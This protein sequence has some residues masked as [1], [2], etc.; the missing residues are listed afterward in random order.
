[1]KQ[2]RVDIPTTTGRNDIGVKVAFSSQYMPSLVGLPNGDVLLA[3]AHCMLRSKDHGRT[4]G[5]IE[6]LPKKLGAITD[7]GDTMFRTAKGRLI[8][9]HFRG[10]KQLEGPMPKVGISES[11]DNGK[12][13]SDTAWSELAGDWAGGPKNLWPYG[14]AVPQATTTKVQHNRAV[15]AAVGCM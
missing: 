12:T 6:L 7:Y 10:R 8:V 4:W 1:M 9:Q 15:M 5:E 13:W 2:P 14:L 3:A 11:H